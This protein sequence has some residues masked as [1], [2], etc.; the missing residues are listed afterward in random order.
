MKKKHS[1]LLRTLLLT[2]IP[3]TIILAFTIPVGG[4]VPAVSYDSSAAVSQENPE[5]VDIPQEGIYDVMLDSVC[6]PLTYYNQTDARWG[7]YLYGG[8]DPL[9]IYGCGP[10]VMAMLITSLTGN[11]VLPTDLARWASANK[12]WSPG[13]GSYHRLI[14]DSASA[15]GLTAEPLKDYTARGIKDTLNSGYLIVALM[16]KGHFT[17]QGHF[18][19]ITSF[20]EEGKLRIADSNNYDHTLMEWEPSLILQELKYRSSNGGPLWKIIPYNKNPALPDEY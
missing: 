11:H 9:S 16:N 4:E 18:I 17:Q 1:V 7:N 6:G 15:Y 8:Q 3:F 10:T 5:P 19:I 12:S 13:E 20:T 2:A 14:S